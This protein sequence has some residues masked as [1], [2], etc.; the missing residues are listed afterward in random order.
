MQLA[1]RSSFFKFAISSP[2]IISKPCYLLKFGEL[3]TTVALDHPVVSLPNSVT[4]V[5]VPRGSTLAAAPAASASE[6][7]DI[8]RKGRG[9]ETG[10][11]T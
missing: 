3:G 7:P 1:A 11:G 5:P 9:G 6:L 8:V 10:T 2:T 4:P